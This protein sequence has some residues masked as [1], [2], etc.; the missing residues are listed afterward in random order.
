MSSHD[1]CEANKSLFFR[2]KNFWVARNDRRTKNWGRFCCCAHFQELQNARFVLGF[3]LPQRHIAISRNQKYPNTRGRMPL[4]II[5]IEWY[6]K[7]SKKLRPETSTNVQLS[8]LL[9]S[10]ME[11]RADRFD[12]MR[13][14]VWSCVMGIGTCALC[15]NN[16]R[17]RQLDPHGPDN[18][19]NTQSSIEE[20][21][22][23]HNHHQRS[24]RFGRSANQN[25]P[26][27]WHFSISPTRAMKLHWCSGISENHKPR[28]CLWL[29]LEMHKN[30]AKIL[31]VSLA[32]IHSESGQKS[33]IQRGMKLLIC[34]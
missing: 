19:L 24:A 26:K 20:R 31:R 32:I 10:L 30:R 28:I 3:L 33:R 5:P 27:I 22:D 11:Y 9:I 17:S 29:I 8:I 1:S 4:T 7:G 13:C 23:V 18:D 12:L 25:K 16:A 14:L 6:L 21:V 2:K 15:F 34:K